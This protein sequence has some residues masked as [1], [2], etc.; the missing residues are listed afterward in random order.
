MLYS[1][2]LLHRNGVLRMREEIVYLLL[3]GLG[4]LTGMIGATSIMHLFSH[5]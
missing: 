4:T 3:V 1:W 5:I 2:L